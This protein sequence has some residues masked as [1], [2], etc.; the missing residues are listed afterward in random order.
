MVLAST[1]GA[2]QSGRPDGVTL[3]NFQFGPHNRWAFSHIREVI[4]TTN[5]PH[6]NE[7][8]LTLERHDQATDNRVIEWQGRSQSLDEIAEAH[9]LDGVLVLKGNEILIE[10]YYGEL[11]AER[12]HLMMS[13]TKSVVGLLAG[14]LAAAGVVDLSKPVSAYVP[15]LADG[16]WGP[17][18]LQVLLDMQDG[19]DYTED[20][21][22]M[23]STVRLQDCA[24]GWTDADYC[25]D[26]G[27]VGGY[28]FYPTIGRNEENLGKF[29][30]KSGSTD[31]IGWVL[32][33]AT[34]RP[35]AELISE[36]IWKPMGAEF[37]ANITVDSSGFVLGDGGMNATLRDLGRF[38]LLAL[39]DGVAFGE[40]IVPAAFIEDI[41]NHPGDPDWP[42]SSAPGEAPYYRSFWWGRGNGE[43]DIRGLGIHGQYLHVA[44]EAG[45]VIVFYSTWPT[46]DPDGDGN[47][48]G[49]TAWYALSA[50]L[51]ETFR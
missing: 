48:Y 37:D 17:D 40:Q 24:V 34:G 21:D 1:P 16:G 6:D 3:E 45:I 7:R 8:V 46:A 20:Y 25:P 2:A 23:S 26:D 15:E 18:S 11:T 43:G 33:A 44:P 38:G 39:N 10:R 41:E 29:V 49:W 9:N 42:Y 36:H 5:I 4:P 13:V 35:L 51:I 31:V 32:E 12:P 14:K 19:A 30:Y 50:A 28:A 47:S 22:D 27:P